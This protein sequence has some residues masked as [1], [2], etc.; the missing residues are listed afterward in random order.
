VIRWPWRR[1]G[2]PDPTR[3]LDELRRTNFGADYNE[4]DRYRDFRAVFYGS[5]AGQRVLM[6][7][8]GWGGLYDAVES[9]PADSEALQRYT[10]R[11]E[12]ALDIMTAL[13]AEPKGPAT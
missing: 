9:I 5:P 3:F 8:L 10:G 6:S 12:L 2:R 7:I 11:R 13:N 4:T 1:L